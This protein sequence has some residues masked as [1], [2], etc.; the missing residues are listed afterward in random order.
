MRSNKAKKSSTKIM[1]EPQISNNE[2]KGEPF[3]QDSHC[4][5]A[6]E[7]IREIDRSMGK[8]KKTNGAANITKQRIHTI[9]S[10][11]SDEHDGGWKKST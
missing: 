9:R 7:V 5:L 8:G 3:Y 4:D 6:I 1:N 10:D 11:T 2:G